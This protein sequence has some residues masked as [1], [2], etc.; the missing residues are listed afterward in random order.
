MFPA[1]DEFC[2]T[3]FGNNN[4]YCQDNEISWLDWGRLQTYQKI[5]QFF[6]HMIGFRKRHPAIQGTGKA[7]VCGFPETSLH[8]RKPWKADY[9]SDGGV[10]AV[11]FAGYDP[12][13]N[14]DDIV[15][16]IINAFWEAAEVELPGLPEGL[17]WQMEINT[18]AE[19]EEYRDIPLIIGNSRVLAGERSVLILTAEKSGS[20]REAA[21]KSERN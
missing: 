12:H 17:A 10:V 5:Y 3:Q 13:R 21:K 20:R 11:M 6:R 1:G 19:G 4:A 9:E 14:Q 2:N 15:Y 18:G 7:A 16:L 8:G